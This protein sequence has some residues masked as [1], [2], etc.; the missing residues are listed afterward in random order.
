MKSRQGCLI[1]A[2]FFCFHS[3]T[4]SCRKIQFSLFVTG[5]LIMGVRATPFF[6]SSII[7]RYALA[8]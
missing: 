6:K 4:F 7:P 3:G 2:L 1:A 8:T 5:A